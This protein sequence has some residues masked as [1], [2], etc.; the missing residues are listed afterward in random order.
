MPPDSGL[1]TLAARTRFIRCAVEQDAAGGPPRGLPLEAVL[2]EVRKA[3]E[4]P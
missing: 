3:A 2:R 1:R 4:E